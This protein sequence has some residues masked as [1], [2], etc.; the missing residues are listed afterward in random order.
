VVL[1]TNLGRAPLAA[2][3]YGVQAIAA[4]YSTLELDSATGTRG[5]A[6]I[7]APRSCQNWPEPRRPW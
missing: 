6:A 1:H 7:T 3:A 2:A 5:D 4:G